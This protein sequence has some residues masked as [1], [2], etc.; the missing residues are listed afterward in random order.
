MVE[1]MGGKCKACGFNPKDEY[2]YAAFDF[3][4]RD[5]KTKS[6]NMGVSMRSLSS[7]MAEAKKCDLLCANCHRVLHAR[8]GRI[9]GRPRGTPT[10]LKMSDTALMELVAS[11]AP[12]T[13]KQHAEELGRTYGCGWRAVEARVR[14]L[15]QRRK[16]G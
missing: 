13:F 5:P 15:K 7:L 16:Q 1:E 8:E 10:K 9:A 4:H 6:F 3:H 11:W 12:G 14:R 2:D